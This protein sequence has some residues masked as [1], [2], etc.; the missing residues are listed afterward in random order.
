VIDGDI[1]TLLG[2]VVGNFTEVEV[3]A[4]AEPFATY[5]AAWGDTTQAVAA[6]RTTLLTWGGAAITTE[7]DTDDVRTGE[8]GDDVGE[9]TFTSGPT[10]VT[11]E[12]ELA[13]DLEDPGPWW[14]LTNPGVL[15]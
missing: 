8:A 14:R 5:E 1:L 15:F 13:V 3:A 6:D 4:D 11:V 2:T 10:S 7:V 9:V 12:L